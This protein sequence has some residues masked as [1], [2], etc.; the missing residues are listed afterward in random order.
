MNGLKIKAKYTF[1]LAELDEA[2]RPINNEKIKI[3]FEL[4]DINPTKVELE[5]ILGW[6]LIEVTVP[7]LLIKKQ[8]SAL[9]YYVP[10]IVFEVNEDDGKFAIRPGK[11]KRRVRK[12]R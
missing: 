5:K 10:N 8:L 6:D 2:L 1:R 3:L 11:K 12:E 7:N 9:V 4:L